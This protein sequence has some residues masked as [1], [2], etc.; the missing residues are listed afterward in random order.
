[1]AL[2]DTLLNVRIIEAALES[3]RTRSVVALS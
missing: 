3:S 2:A 1:V